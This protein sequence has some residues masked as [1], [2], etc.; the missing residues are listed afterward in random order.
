MSTFLDIA[1]PL[2]KADLP[3]PTLNVL[4]PDAYYYEVL[5]IQSKGEIEL[6]NDFTGPADLPLAKRKFS[7][8]VKSA[9]ENDFDLVLSPEYSY[10]WDVLVEAIEREKLPKFGK[11][12]AFGCESITPQNL[13]SIKASLPGI[14]WIHE[15]ISTAQ[16]NFL[17]PLCYLPK[18]KKASGETVNV[19]LL[20][21]KTQGIADRK[22]AFERDRL[23]CGITT[24][25]PHKFGRAHT[26]FECGCPSTMRRGNKPRPVCVDH[27]TRVSD[28]VHKRLR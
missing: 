12:W 22:H 16:G 18:T 1:E 14:E 23:I 19:G 20:Q 4:T 3:L 5:A 27:R 7:G 11:M 25:F 8:F 28:L 10:P 17:D 21:F 26:V 6:H 15:T 13:D 2:R 9:V 24:Y